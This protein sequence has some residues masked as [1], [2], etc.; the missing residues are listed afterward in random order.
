MNY[1]P[2]RDGVKAR[3]YWYVDI[4]RQIQA[5][6]S[7]LAIEGEINQVTSTLYFYP[8]LA[9]YAVQDQLTAELQS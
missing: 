4:K 6:T 7:F 9:S 3:P 1:N 5:Q 2:I 8:T